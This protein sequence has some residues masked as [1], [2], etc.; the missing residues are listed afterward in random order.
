[1]SYDWFMVSKVTV[2]EFKLAKI[3]Q[4]IPGI[5]A[6]TVVLSLPEVS[7]V[8]NGHTQGFHLAGSETVYEIGL[9][10]TKK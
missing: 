6:S 9:R 1:M 7:G 3:T 8:A 2:N 5:L 4:T 10:Y